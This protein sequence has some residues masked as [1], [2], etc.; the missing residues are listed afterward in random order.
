VVTS[1]TAAGIG[2]GANVYA[3]TGTADIQGQEQP[4]SWLIAFD[5]TRDI[6]VACLVLN[7]GYGASVA[8]PEVVSFLS[9]Y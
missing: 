5:P 9:H 7:A 3:K 4:N 1:G 8:G 6:A 2:L